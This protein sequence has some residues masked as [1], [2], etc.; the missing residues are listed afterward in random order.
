MFTPA[1]QEPHMTAMKNAAHLTILAIWVVLGV[2]FSLKTLFLPALLPIVLFWAW[3]AG[4]AAFTSFLSNQFKGPL[5]AVGVHGAIFLALHL[6]PKV[7]PFGILR[8]GV[9]LLF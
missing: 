5:A 7:M 1:E 8:V 2:L 3:F 4:Y 9:D 6:V